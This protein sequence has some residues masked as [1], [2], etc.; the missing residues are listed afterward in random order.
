MKKDD[1]LVPTR[2]ITNYFMPLTKTVGKPFSPPRSN[3]IKDY[4]Q[5]T[6]PAQEKI[7]SVKKSSDVHSSE[8]SSSQDTSAKPIGALKQKR[9][10][11][12]KLQN[13]LHEQDILGFDDAIITDRPCESMVREEGSLAVCGSD[14]EALLSQI[15]S[16]ICLDV[17]SLKCKNS[18]QPSEDEK[19]VNKLTVQSTAGDNLGKE[20]KGR[21]KKSVVRTNR[22]VKV[23]ESEGCIE[24]EGSLQNTSLE[25]TVNETS[26]LNCS[27][28]TV[29]FEDFVQS[30]VHKNEDISTD[31][32]SD[33][34]A[35]KLL[36]ESKSFIDV[37]NVELAVPHV[38]PRTLTVQAE[39]HPVSPELVKSPQLR[40]ASIFTRNKKSRMVDDKIVTTPQVAADVLPDH[41]RK[42]NVVLYEED[43]ELAV[44][45][46]GSPTKCSQEERK[47][48]MNAFKQHGSDG[49]KAKMSK[50]S[51]KLKQ[52]TQENTPD[53]M[54]PDGKT[55]DKNSD[56]IKQK[57]GTDNNINS[58]MKRK[59]KKSLKKVKKGSATQEEISP[60]QD[61]QHTPTELGNVK[62]PVAD[63]DMSDAK[64]LRR[65]T[66][67]PTR[68]QTTSVPDTD[69]SPRKTRRQGKAEILAVSPNSV[70]QASTPKS[71]RT[72]SSVY[73]AEMLS[74]VDKQG[75]PIR[76]VPAIII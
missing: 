76:Y 48:F 1:D 14:T 35:A 74:V 11:K 21:T 32:N 37:N 12:I 44:V 39:V 31:F 58:G 15:G 51:G 24:E 3:N 68:R 49:S 22:T 9:T 72:K 66:R 13:K 25:V 20:G 46:S 70:L 10:R 17:E 69:P 73:R 34:C 71:C 30:Q 62:D 50:S 61:D 38:S 27:T 28:I 42:S 6:P 60:N 18:T 52:E 55:D 8:S 43:L 29:S 41:R 26:V 4:F 16:E 2:T 53:I 23:S 56:Q 36:H 54:Q 40:M 33:E 19:K 47:Q 75:S 57:Q 7:S 64:V 45:E 67:T 59:T 63:S 65:S 5:K